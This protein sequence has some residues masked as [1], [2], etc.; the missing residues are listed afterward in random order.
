V[1][2]TDGAPGALKAIATTWPDT[3]VQ[4][5]LIH[6]RRDTV[7]D[8]ALHPRTAQGRALPGLSRKLP[9]ITTT[10]RAAHRPAALNDYAT[11]YRTRLN[12]RTT[13]QDDPATAAALVDCLLVAAILA[14]VCF[15]KHLPFAGVGFAAVVALVP[16]VFLFR[17]FSGIFQIAAGDTSLVTLGATAQDAASALLIILAMAIGIALPHEF[18]LRRMHRDRKI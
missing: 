13:A 12:Q 15:H 3:K 18:W 4:R 5:C 17:A 6:V 11:E 10:N 7:R 16:G 2:T 14:P 8:P 1:T 9:T